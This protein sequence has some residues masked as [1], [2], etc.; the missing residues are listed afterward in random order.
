MTRTAALPTVDIEV[1]IEAVREAATDAAVAGA[2]AVRA[3]ASALAPV[4]GSAVPAAKNALTPAVKTAANEL[5]S[6]LTSAGVDVSALERARDD[7]A[8][9]AAGA[10]ADALAKGA[11]A[12]APLIASALTTSAGIVTSKPETALAAAGVGL[13]AIQV[14]PALGSSAVSAFRGYR[15]D[16]GAADALKM[17]GEKGCFLV[18]V[19]SETEKISSGV[20]DLPSSA[21]S[22]LVSISNDQLEDRGVRGMLRNASAVEAEIA[23]LKIASLRKLNKGSTILVLDAKCGPTAKTIAK[24]LSEYGYGKVFCIAGGFS[25]RGG[26]AQSKLGTA[27]LFKSTGRVPFFASPEIVDRGGTSGSTM[28]SLPGRK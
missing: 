14:L 10:V 24:K 20:P 1:D 16:V 13:I 3:T 28:R 23:A 21:K 18:D 9:P 15:G 17:L 19:R 25:G 12:L 7:I 8:A 27:D 5:S 11:S 26:W 6:A 22:A 2:D 4:L